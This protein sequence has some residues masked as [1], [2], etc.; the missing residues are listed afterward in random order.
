MITRREDTAKAHYYR[1]CIDCRRK[2]AVESEESTEERCYCCIRERRRQ[3]AEERFTEKLV[4][5]AITGVSVQDNEKVTA[6]YIKTKKGLQLTLK[7]ES[8]EGFRYI[9]IT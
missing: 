2:F 8:D 6:I 5:A 4:S 7:A 1:T 9:D 3:E